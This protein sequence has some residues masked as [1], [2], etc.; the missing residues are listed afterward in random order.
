MKR[1]TPKNISNRFCQM[2]F[3]FL[4]AITKPFDEAIAVASKAIDAAVCA[5]IPSPKIAAPKTPKVASVLN[6]PSKRVSFGP[7]V[8]PELIDKV[9]TAFCSI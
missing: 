9:R 4:G 3:L 5:V 1:L 6:T 7:Y 8:S 2:H